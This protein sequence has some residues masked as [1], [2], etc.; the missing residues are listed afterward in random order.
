[1]TVAAPLS[2]LD[3]KYVVFGR[4]ISGMRALKVMEK[5]ETINE[6]PKQAVKITGAGDYNISKKK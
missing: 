6:K 3:G 5:M 4:V 2:F 1:M